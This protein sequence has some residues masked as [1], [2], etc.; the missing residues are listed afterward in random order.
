MLLV[1]IEASSL[2]TETDIFSNSILYSFS[3]SFT[4]ASN[5]SD[6]S[7]RMKLEM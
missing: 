2:K 7:V 1:L 6:E 3:R 5:F 4:I